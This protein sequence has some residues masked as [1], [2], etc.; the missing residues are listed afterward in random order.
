MVLCADTE[1][2]GGTYKGK[3]S[4]WS[5]FQMADDWKVSV[6]GAGSAS[7][8]DR[9]VL[10]HRDKLQGIP[11]FDREKIVSATEEAMRSV[12]ERYV[13]PVMPQI[14]NSFEILLAM[15]ARGDRQYLFSVRGDL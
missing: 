12:Y 7:A 13:W 1:E 2:S 8:I 9:F 4:K 11:T 10:L 14:D 5:Q 15:Q 6:G 3:V